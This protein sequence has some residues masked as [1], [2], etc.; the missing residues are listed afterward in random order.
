MASR[1]DPA[2][3]ERVAG[4]YEEH[5]GAWD[6][7]RGRDLRERPWLDRFAAMLPESGTI[8]DLGCGMGE[9]VARYLI[10]Q[11]FALTGIDSSPS[12]IALCRERFPDHEWLVGDMRRLDLG[13]RFDGLI[14][15]HSLF[16]L[17]PDDQRPLFSR[18]ADHAGPGAALLFTSGPHQGEEIGEWM[19]EPLYHGSLA[20]EEYEA[21]LAA[22]GFGEA[23]CR[24]PDPGCG[25]ATIWL[26]RLTP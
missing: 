7:M 9:P 21:L 23:T 11:G 25:E 22:S 12:L 19:G 1:S 16:H 18:F 24:S 8:L 20:P 13:R 26:A 10:E 2:P 15:W 14:A 3:N 6:R 4:L 5:A 17:S